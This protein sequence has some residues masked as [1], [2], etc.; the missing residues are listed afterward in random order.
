M[1]EVLSPFPC[2]NQTER[3]PV[4]IGEKAESRNQKSAGLALCENTIFVLD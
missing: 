3:T 2:Q 1:Q 4:L